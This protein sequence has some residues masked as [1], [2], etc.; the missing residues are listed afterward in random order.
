MTF[1]RFSYSRKDTEHLLREQTKQGVVFLHRT[2][3]MGHDLR[4]NL[5]LRRVHVTN[6]VLGGLF[7]KAGR[8]LSV[9][10][11]QLLDLLVKGRW[12]VEPDLSGSHKTSYVIVIIIPGKLGLSRPI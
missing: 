11:G 2:A 8:R 6:V 9:V 7:K 12:H 3:G 1:N 10:L 4:P 5:R